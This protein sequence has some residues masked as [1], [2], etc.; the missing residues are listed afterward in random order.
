MKNFGAFIIVVGAFA[1]TLVGSYHLM[2]ASKW[3][4]GFGYWPVGNVQYYLF[5]SGALMLA[6]IGSITI[7]FDYEV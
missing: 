6:L 1:L 2:C 4:L 3:A 7:S 5:L